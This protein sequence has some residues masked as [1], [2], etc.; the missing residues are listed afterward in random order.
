[1]A[2]DAAHRALRASQR[3]ELKRLDL[4]AAGQQGGSP[5]DKASTQIVT[6]QALTLTL[7]FTLTLTLTLTLP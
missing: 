5:A 1:M 6:A 3:A 4:A 7:I 2:Q